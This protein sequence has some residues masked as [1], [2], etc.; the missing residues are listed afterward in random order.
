MHKKIK[1]NYGKHREKRTAGDKLKKYS[2]NNHY[3]L[4]LLHN[5]Q[6]KK[7]V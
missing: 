3:D 2:L 7:E 6:K 4:S 1:R 5:F